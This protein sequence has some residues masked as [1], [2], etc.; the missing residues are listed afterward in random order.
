GCPGATKDHDLNRDVQGQSSAR[1]HCLRHV[2]T[3]LQDGWLQVFLSHLDR[4]FILAFST[5]AVND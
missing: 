1:R 4:I 3:I 2:L 5:C